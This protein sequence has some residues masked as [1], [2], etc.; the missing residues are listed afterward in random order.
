MT[1]V[2]NKTGEN[3]KDLN[4]NWWQIPDYPY[5]TLVIGSSEGRKRNAPLNPIHQ[6]DKNISVKTFLYAKVPYEPKYPL[7]NK[8]KIQ[9]IWMIFIKALKNTSQI[10]NTKY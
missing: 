6:Q 9:M 2:G 3:I 5:R 7:I 10:K 4:P 1:N 8:H